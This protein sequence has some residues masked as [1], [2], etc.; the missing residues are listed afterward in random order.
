MIASAVLKVPSR[1]PLL[2]LFP[3]QASS[4]TARSPRSRSRS[5]RSSAR[6]CGRRSTRAWCAHARRVAGLFVCAGACTSCGHSTGICPPVHHMACQD[7]PLHPSGL[8]NCA[9]HGPVPGVRPGAGC[10]GG[11]PALVLAVCCVACL[12]RLLLPAVFAHA[13]CAH[14]LPSAHF[15][16][17]S[18]RTGAAPP[19]QIET[20]Q[21]ETIHP[22]KS[23]KMN[24]SCAGELLRPA[25]CI[26]RCVHSETG[27]QQQARPQ[28]G[29]QVA[30]VGGCA[31][32]AALNA[33]AMP[34][35]CL[36]RHPAVRG[37]QVA[38]VQAQPHG[39]H[40]RRL[41]PEAL[42]QV[43]GGRAAALG[44]LRQPRH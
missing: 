30:G 28:R 35:A 2:A 18:A 33:S 40:Q 19:P 3:G 14:L 38:N 11:A 26:H 29:Q 43:L 25:A 7:S 42:Q 10:A 4:C 13:T 6:I 24:S 39:R 15:P 31:H 37:L 36:R 27:R 1:I 17:L 32:H 22:R 44:R 5:S 12:L 23:Y 20:V 34:P 41:R 16:T 21:K 9:G 8:P